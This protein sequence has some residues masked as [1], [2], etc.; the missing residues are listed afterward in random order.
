MLACLA[1][2]PRKAAEECLLTDPA[3]INEP[4]DRTSQP[5]PEQECIKPAQT[6][7]PHLVVDGLKIAEAYREQ[8][9]TIHGVNHVSADAYLVNAF[10][11][12]EARDSVGVDWTVDGE[13]RVARPGKAKVVWII[14]WTG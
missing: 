5:L 4:K 7:Q 6:C 8:Q 9:A 12:G 1:L 11:L 10:H 3:D 2:L 14:R 13:V